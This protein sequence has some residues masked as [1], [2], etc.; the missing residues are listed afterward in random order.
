MSDKFFKEYIE[1]RTVADI[2]EDYGEQ[3]AEWQTLL[4][5]ENGKVKSFRHSNGKTF[6]CEHNISYSR[7]VQ[8]VFNKGE[9]VRGGKEKL[10][11][12]PVPVSAS[13]QK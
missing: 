1:N 11:S 9:S 4:T 2:M 13:L 6:Y 3:R 10:P 12:T 8:L 7:L 5:M